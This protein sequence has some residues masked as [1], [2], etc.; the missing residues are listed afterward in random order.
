M[1]RAEKEYISQRETALVSHVKFFDRKGDGYIRPWDTYNG[2]RE[3]GFGIILSLYAAFLIALAMGWATNERW[4][5]WPSYTVKVKNIKKAR[6][7]SDSQMYDINGNFREHEFDQLFASFD[8]DGDG[9]L[10]FLELLRMTEKF[11][12]ST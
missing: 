7:G 6:H 1:E 10:S 4:N 11:R 9:R 3:I 12:L 8:T 5:W 2:F